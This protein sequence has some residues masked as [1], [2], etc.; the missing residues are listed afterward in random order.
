MSLQR[1]HF[2]EVICFGDKVKRLGTSIPVW[3]YALDGL[4]VDT[5]PAT[6]RSALMPHLRELQPRQAALTHLHEDHSGQ[7][8]WLQDACQTAV[9]LPSGSLPYASQP[10]QLPLYRRI[11]WGRRP[12]FEPR[13]MPEELVTPGGYRLQAIPTP[14]HMQEHAALFE[15]QHGWLFSGDLY[16]RTRPKL[17]FVDERMDDMIQSLQRCLQLDVQTLFCAH[18]GIVEQGRQALQS[19]LDY[20]V[21]LRERKREL[22]RQGMGLKEIDR[23]LFPKKPLITYLSKGEWSSRHLLRTL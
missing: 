17:G 22:E 20:L 15:P 16:V 11:F 6:L 19:K 18:A 10:A 14:G 21:E 8:G 7:A 3:L 13:P 23:S 9:Y 2:Q 4:L 1:K 5:G 12:P